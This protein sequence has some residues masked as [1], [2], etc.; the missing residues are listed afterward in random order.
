MILLF[1]GTPARMFP[2]QI[3]AMNLYRIRGSF[4]FSE[5]SLW[6]LKSHA[7]MHFAKPGG[8]ML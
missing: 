4:L 3:R 1:I 7:Q 5:N 2:S 6:G 8:L